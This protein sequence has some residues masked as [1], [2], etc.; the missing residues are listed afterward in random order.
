MSV[1]QGEIYAE[2]KNREEHYDE[3]IKRMGGNIMRI[4]NLVI[5]EKKN[6]EETHT[7]FMTILDTLY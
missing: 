7:D 1:L 2:K 3:L 6:R 5:N 4:N